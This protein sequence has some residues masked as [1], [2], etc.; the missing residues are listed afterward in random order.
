MQDRKIVKL[1]K[2]EEVELRFLM[3]TALRSTDLDTFKVWLNA[4]PPNLVLKV[5]RKDYGIEAMLSAMSAGN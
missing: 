1:T 5:M 3:K 4:I 2:K